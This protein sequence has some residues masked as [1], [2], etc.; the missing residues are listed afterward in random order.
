M[1][2][3][4]SCG[5]LEFFSDGPNADFFESPLRKLDQLVVPTVCI[6]EVFK[7]ILIDKDESSALQAI[8]QMKQG[9]VINMDDSLAMSAAKISFEL[10]I[11]MA[12]SIILATSKQFNATIWTQNGH[13]KDIPVKYKIKFK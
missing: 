8:A 5:W 1:N 4:D 6:Y 9:Q 10:K 2:L 7:K 12:D 11:P 3:V 13:F